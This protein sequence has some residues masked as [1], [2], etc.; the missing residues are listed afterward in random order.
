MEGRMGLL[1]LFVLGGAWAC[2]AREL[3]NL[4]SSELSRNLDVCGLCIEYASMALRFLNENK[5][6][7]EII[8]ILHHSC[9]QL[10]AFKQKCISL[11]DKYAPIFFL[12]VS[13]IKPDEFCRKISLCQQIADMALLVQENSCAFCKDTI[14]ALLAKLKDPDTELEIV[15][16]LLQVCN[17]VEKYANKCKRIVFEYGP[18]IFENAEKFLE[19]TDICTVLHACKASTAVDQQSLFF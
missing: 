13:I 6:H 1:F 8:D 7:T 17:T 16:K 10:P 9:E 5:T 18:M 4:G 14:S 2:D 19:T 15:E 3:E 12:E 11:V